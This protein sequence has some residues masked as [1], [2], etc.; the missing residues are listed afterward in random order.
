MLKTL[1]L[2]ILKNGFPDSIAKGVEAPELDPCS[3]CLEDY[4]KDLLQC[5]ICAIEIEPLLINTA[6]PMET[7]PLMSNQNQETISSESMALC[8][9]NLKFPIFQLM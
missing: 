7:S 5:P 9:S 1:A 3:R 6:V 4:A 2:N 8:A